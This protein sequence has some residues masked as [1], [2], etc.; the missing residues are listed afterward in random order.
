MYEIK[1]DFADQCGT[2]FSEEEKQTLKMQS[3][4]A[5]LGGDHFGHITLNNLR[6][7]MLAIKGVVVLMSAGAAIAPG[8]TEASG[9]SVEDG[10]PFETGTGTGTGAGT[11]TAASLS[12][13]F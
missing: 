11:G 3:L 13:I 2:Q 12:S 10:I 5:L 4:W 6:M 9:A 8:N 7:L 1:Q